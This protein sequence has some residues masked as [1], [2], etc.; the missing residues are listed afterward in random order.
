MNTKFKSLI[1]DG[2][3]DYKGEKILNEIFEMS[4]KVYK[5]TL[6]SDI[7]G[8]KPSNKTDEKIIIPEHWFKSKD[9]HMEDIKYIKLISTIS[10]FEIYIKVNF[11]N[12]QKI[13]REGE[14][15]IYYGNIIYKYKVG[16][17]YKYLFFDKCF[18]QNSEYI[19]IDISEEEYDK[20][21]NEFSE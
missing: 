8:I 1:Y 19:E 21:N 11:W 9:K 4:L 6:A 18:V 15:T 5:K 2:G 17:K 12:C 7:K 13:V 3:Y 20:V 10:N 16:E 14:Y